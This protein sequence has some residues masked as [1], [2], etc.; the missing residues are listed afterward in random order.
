MDKKSIFWMIV[1]VVVALSL[2]RMFQGANATTGQGQQQ[3]AAPVQVVENLKFSDVTELVKDHPDQV[4]QLTF[5]NGSSQ[6]VVD[7]TGKAPVTVQIPDDGGKQVLIKSA[8]DNKVAVDAKEAPKKDGPS[9]FEYFFAILIQLLPVIFIVGIIM[10]FM[11]NAGGAGV[12]RQ[13]GNSKA[14]EVVPAADRKTFKDVAGCDE[15]K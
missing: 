3:G 10:F 9:G 5:L 13:L 2:G 7:R 6:V 14:Q 15:A 8:T 1:I 4:K 12:Q 11:K